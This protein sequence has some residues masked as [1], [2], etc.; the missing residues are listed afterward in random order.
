MNREAFIH[1]AIVGLVT[2][3]MMWLFLVATAP[4][5]VPR[6]ETFPRAKCT[7]FETGEWREYEREGRA[8]RE[9]ALRV[10]CTRQD[11]V[12]K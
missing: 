11:W 10:A 6:V 4:K 1:V 5:P 9:H 7:Y 12:R 8:V 2:G 3:F